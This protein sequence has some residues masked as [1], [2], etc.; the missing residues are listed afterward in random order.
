ME[1]EQTRDA[2]KTRASVPGH[3]VDL[4]GWWAIT[5][6]ALSEGQTLKSRDGLFDLCD[7]TES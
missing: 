7:L 2:K 4:A 3:A 5:S 1:S 6:L